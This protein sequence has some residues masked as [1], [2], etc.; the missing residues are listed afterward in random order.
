MKTDKQ[1]H[2]WKRKVVRSCYVGLFLH[3]KAVSF[4]ARKHH[5]LDVKSSKE[6]PQTLLTP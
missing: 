3:D 6:E 5:M 4:N 2:C 1:L